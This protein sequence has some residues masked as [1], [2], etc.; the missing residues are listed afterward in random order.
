MLAFCATVRNIDADKITHRPKV[1]SPH[2]LAHDPFHIRDQTQRQ[3]HGERGLFG[4]DLL[5]DTTRQTNDSAYFAFS[6][7]S[8][9][10][11]MIVRYAT[12]RI[13]LAGMLMNGI[14]CIESAEIG[15]IEAQPA[16]VWVKRSPVPDGPT[17][18]RLGYEGACVWDNRHR[19]LIRYGGHNQGGV[20]NRV[21]KSG[22]SI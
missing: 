11:M 16:N 7:L 6:A 12:L 5:K 10:C 4:Q 13:L 8:F 22:R 21:R 15:E 17:S 2:E 9:R 14:R 3:V 20:G 1:P 18:P 19:L